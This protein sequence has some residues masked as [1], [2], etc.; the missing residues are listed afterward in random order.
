MIRLSTR[1]FRTQGCI[2]LAATG[3]A[4]GFLFLLSQPQ[5]WMFRVSAQFDPLFAHGELDRQALE[6][7]VASLYAYEQ[8]LRRESDIEA[9]PLYPYRLWRAFADVSD[10]HAAFLR[11]PDAR[12]ANALISAW[13]AA[14]RAYRGRTE[15]R[16]EGLLNVIRE[17]PATHERPLV[18][19]G[20]RFVTTIAA[21]QRDNTLAARNAQALEREIAR[22]ACMITRSFS[23]TDE[24]LVIGA[25]T[26]FRWL[27]A[28]LGR[29]RHSL[30]I[31]SKTSLP[32][33]I[34]FPDF[35]EVTVI[36][37]SYAVKTFCLNEDVRRPSSA[38][39]LVADAIDHDGT[40]TRVAAF[41]SDA[42]YLQPGPAF[43]ERAATG[44]IGSYFQ[45]LANHGWK[46]SFQNAATVYM[47]PQFSHILTAFSYAAGGNGA[48]LSG[49]PDALGFIAARGFRFQLRYEQAT[50]RDNETR[51]HFSDLFLVSSKSPFDL[52]FFNHAPAIWRIGEQPPYI[53]P[54]AEFETPPVIV[55]S[56]RELTERHGFE[57]AQAF[58]A[59]LKTQRE[60]IRE[61]MQSPSPKQE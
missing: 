42:F 54:G 60:W 37:G 35:R 18:F 34:L 46:G 31:T 14:A 17:N 11:S 41:A 36:I 12:P 3:I 50:G 16:A 55:T 4:A 58:T 32:T 47:C 49:L 26:L 5:W 2:L 1:R 24:K 57:N 25:R 29:P 59:T 13:N 52:N 23:C 33:E 51:S 10:A 53:D 6:K 8:Q 43:Y 21:L 30:P 22:R 28:I 48:D 20:G 45:Y 40:T 15:E 7:H 19:P 27:G 38:S 56:F 61:F 39:I 44:E 9:F